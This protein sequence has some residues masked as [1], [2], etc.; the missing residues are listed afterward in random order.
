M[1]R[2]LLNSPVL[3]A[4]GRWRYEGPLTRDAARAFVADGRAVSAIG[5]AATARWLTREL[6]VPVACRRV[7]VSLQ[8][9]D[10]A[11]V[12]RLATRLSEGRVLDEA[13]LDAAGPEFALLVR[14]A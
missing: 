4:Y 3:T 14:E 11:L 1:A 7:A 13:A 10:E 6:G 2:Y 12:L 9:G 8:A 5:H